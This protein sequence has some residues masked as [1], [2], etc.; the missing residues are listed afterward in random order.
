MRKL[1]DQMCQISYTKQTY[2]ITTK[3][4]QI[5][6]IDESQTMAPINEKSLKMDLVVGEQA[7]L[8][9]LITAKMELR[10]SKGKTPTLEGLKLASHV[11]PEDEESFYT[12]PCQHKYVVHAEISKMTG[13]GVTHEW[14][15]STSSKLYGMVWSI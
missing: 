14:P 15:P 2:L 8:S 7:N 11:N 5:I 6:H 1:I 3:E 9:K 4:E 10:A 13:L 12:L